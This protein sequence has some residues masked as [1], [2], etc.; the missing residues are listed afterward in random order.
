[1]LAI[2]I[3]VIQKELVNLDGQQRIYDWHGREEESIGGNRKDSED[4]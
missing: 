2:K 3:P 4:H 1:M